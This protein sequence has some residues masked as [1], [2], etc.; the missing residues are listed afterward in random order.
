MKKTLLV[1]ITLELQGGSQGDAG[2]T[3]SKTVTPDSRVCISQF[4][5]LSDKITVVKV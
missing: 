1:G 2:H 5:S 4:L 3:K